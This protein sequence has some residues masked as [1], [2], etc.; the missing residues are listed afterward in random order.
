M[1]NNRMLVLLSLTAT[2]NTEVHTLE[3]AE[4]VVLSALTSND[5]GVSIAQFHSFARPSMYPNVAG[6][7]H[8]I[9]QK[10]VEDAPR[11]TTVYR[12]FSRWLCGV[13]DSFLRLSAE[14]SFKSF[15]KDSPTLTFPNDVV[16]VTWGRHS[17]EQLGRECRRMYIP[18]PFC[19]HIDLQN[20]WRHLFD[21]SILDSSL[22]QAALRLSATVSEGRDFEARQMLAIYQRMVRKHEYY[23][24]L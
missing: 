13:R 4:T 7:D 8:A 20:H 9:T 22:E 14:E 10:N 23:C 2:N 24:L 19:K 1:A 12:N 16:V 3:E 18:V 15:T 11:F 21:V 6:I 5:K 17:L